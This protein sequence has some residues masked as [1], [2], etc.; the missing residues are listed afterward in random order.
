MKHIECS[1]SVGKML[2]KNQ[3][4]YHAANLYSQNCRWILED[5]ILISVNDMHIVAFV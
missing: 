3:P 5:E 2:F 1:G 4:I